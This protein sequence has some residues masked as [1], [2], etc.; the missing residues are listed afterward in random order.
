MKNQSNTESTSKL[1]I[2]SDN[3]LSNKIETYDINDD[4]S[5]LLAKSDTQDYN[6]QTSLDNILN[7]GDPR[8]IVYS[9]HPTR[10]MLVYC[11]H[12]IK[13]ECYIEGV[14]NSQFFKYAIF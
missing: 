14:H 1:S 3:L 12:D 2:D 4:S 10:E 13:S 9:I 11:H 7:L 5:K 6:S 8:E